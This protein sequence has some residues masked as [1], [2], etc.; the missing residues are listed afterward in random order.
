MNVVTGGAGFIGTH[1]VKTL[2]ARGQ[3]VRVIEHPRARVDHLPDGN[4]EI[5]RADI[6]DRD[7]LRLALAGAS[8]V[9]HLAADPNL[10]R[11]RPEEFEE[12][13]HGGTR[14][15]LENALDLGAKRI[16]YV[17]TESILSSVKLRSVAVEKLELCEAD[18]IGPYCLSKYRAERFAFELAGQGA[19]VVVASPTLPVGPG[20]RNQTPPTRMALAFCRGAMPGYLDCRFNLIDARDVAEGLVRALECG[21]PTIR[22][23]L[24]HVNVRLSDWLRMLAAVCGRKPPRLQVPYAVALATAWVSERWAD[25]VSGEMPLATVTGVRLTRRSMHFDPSASLDELGIR[26][27]DIS[28]SARDAVAWYHAQGWL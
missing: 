14:N 24:G 23:L 16:L 12:V 10:W 20:D 27:R 13:N 11:R 22:Y 18:M 9:Y 6:R 7:A 26:P 28:E 8:N 17:S 2:V 15:V 5:V 1:L 25:Y 4:V 21:R 19:P 3:S